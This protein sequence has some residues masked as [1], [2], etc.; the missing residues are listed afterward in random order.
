MQNNIDDLPPTG[1]CILRVYR[2]FSGYHWQLT[3]FVFS[4]FGNV[5]HVRNWFSGSDSDTHVALSKHDETEVV[6]CGT[7]VGLAISGQ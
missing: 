3:K 7:Q 4:L 5:F 2:K 1:L 6:C